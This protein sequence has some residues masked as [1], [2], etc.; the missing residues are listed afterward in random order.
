LAGTLRPTAMGKAGA[1][2]L[3]L[4]ASLGGAEAAGLRVLVVHDTGA[5]DASSERQAIFFLRD[6]LGHFGCRVE[7]IEAE[8]YAAG[9][10][11]AHDATVYL[12]LRAGAKLPEAFLAD[13]YDTERPICW[14]GSNLD[15]LAARFS[16]GRYGFRLDPEQPAVRPRRVVHRGLSYWRSPALLSP[17]AVM[18]PDVCE[19]LGVAEGEDRGYP[20]AVRS[21]P[22]WYFPE[23]PVL[24]APGT[25]TYLVL[26][27]QLH[28]F[29]GVRHAPRRTALLMIHGVAADTEPRALAQ[30]VQQLRAEEIAFGICV[31]PVIGAPEGRGEVRLSERRALVSVLRG[32]QREGAS[33]VA[34]ALGA[35]SVKATKAMQPGG[36]TRRMM[37]EALRELVRCGLYPL[38]WAVPR[39]LPEG[40]DAGEV[41]RACSTLWRRSTRG[42]QEPE[43]QEPPFLV[44]VSAHGQAV[45]PDN[46][47]GLR[48][49]R[50]EVE[51]IIEQA[52]RQ[53]AVPDPWVTAS[54][55]PEAP[56]HSVALLVHGLRG[57]EYRF[58]DLSAMWNWTRGETV[59]VYSVGA[60]TA[61]GELIPEEWDGT[62]LEPAA[63]ARRRFERPGRDGREEAAVEPGAVL[64]AYP[65]GKRPRTVFALDSDPDELTSKL[66]YAIARVVIVFA[67][68]AGIVL[69]SVY[70]LQ[71]TLARRA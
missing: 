39:E 49:G 56:L 54:V 44:A 69:L 38:A 47:M 71:V 27:D 30:L 67:L 51:A 13:C 15:Q 20:Y 8:A 2:M 36:P 3:L 31:R 62:V 28:E 66:V 63:G 16:L 42:A 33:I 6:M 68:A 43:A 7:A 50:G 37:E 46:L 1:I 40:L 70:L 14:L 58:A 34:D 19:T 53:A 24:D 12:G 21:G 11:E 4:L 48:Q 65:R 29:L 52:R 17:V 22:F 60:A 5:L 59:H 61:A 10:I 64:V 9:D 23:V 26:A 35:D 55:A 41:A 25:T 18:Q 32:A 45:I 57:M